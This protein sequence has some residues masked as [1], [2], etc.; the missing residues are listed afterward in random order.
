MLRLTSVLIICS[1]QLPFLVLAKN[2]WNLTTDAKIESVYWPKA[3]GEDTNNSLNRLELIPTLSGRL[4]DSYRF[5]FKPN[6]LWDPQNKSKEEQVFFDASEVNLKYKKD[7]TSVQVGNNI[8]NWGVTDGYNPLDVVNMRQYYDPL[9]SVKLGALSMLL[10]H[11]SET[12][13]QEFVYI[14]K[15]QSSILPGTH[16]RWL[17]R[18]IYIPRSIDNN[19]VLLLPEN[20]NYTYESRENINNAPDNNIGLR[21][22]WHLGSVD[23]SLNGFEGVASFPLIQP[24]VTGTV[25]QISPKVIFRTDPNIVLGTK[26]Y[27]YKVAG[28]SWV[29]SQMNFLLKFATSYSQ[30][31]GD[32]PLL[33][34]W[35]HENVV[36]LE[37]NFKLGA[38]GLLVGILQYSYINSEKE[39]NSNLSVAEIFRNTWM[40]GG[41]FSWGDRWALSTFALYDSL[42]Y[43]NFQQYSVTRRIY[44]AWTLQ[45]SAELISGNKD[46]PLGV[47]NDNDNYRISL[48]H[49]F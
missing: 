7:T 3:S 37:K 26:N 18:Q 47:Y 31:M 34:G 25:V 35:T 5:Y 45:L 1:S 10:S 16:S 17:P 21:L 40:A 29:S 15:N 44:D 23:L 13:E 14:P 42:R 30:S 49:S 11:N 28:F 19:V 24:K 27:R 48:S 20:L 32:D 9:H 12:S 41:R 43:S 6:F 8:L 22:Q 39:N 38:E 33:P 46:T 2:T 36:G 4:S